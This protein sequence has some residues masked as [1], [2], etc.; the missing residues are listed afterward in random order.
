MRPS[1][2]GFLVPFLLVACETPLRDLQLTPSFLDELE[3][4]YACTDNVALAR[5]FDGGTFFDG[6]GTLRLQV[7]RDSDGEA[8]VHAFLGR[9]LDNPAEQAIWMAYSCTRGSFHS[10]TTEDWRTIAVEGVTLVPDP[11]F[12][13]SSEYRVEDVDDYEGTLVPDGV[14]GSVPVGCAILDL[15]D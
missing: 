6:E 13:E 14:V 3:R 10:T 9:D 1:S 4:G 5:P 8:T 15:P 11:R 12:A 7:G 2:I